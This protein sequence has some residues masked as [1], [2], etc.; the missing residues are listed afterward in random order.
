MII[1][2][3]QYNCL[4]CQK[5][6]ELFLNMPE[7]KIYTV[8]LRETRQRSR[9]KRAPHAIKI[10]KDYVSRHAKAK[11][12]RI[13]RHLNEKL[14]EKGI[15]NPPRKVRIT[16]EKE[17]DVA[18]VELMGFRYEDFKAKPKTERKGVK[19]KLLSRLGPKAAK[20]EEEEK[21]IEGKDKKSL[22][23][24]EKVDKHIKE[25]GE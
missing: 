7:D 20:K 3:K 14:W 9:R 2:L 15:K 12:I 5:S 21:R 19:E 22:P 6:T 13:G 10:V 4:G 18:K 1:I 25:T 11:E 8:P 17:G 16:I 24:P 23:A